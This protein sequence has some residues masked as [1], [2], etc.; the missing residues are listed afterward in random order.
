LVDRVFPE[1]SLAALRGAA[2]A[3]LAASWADPEH[4]PPLASAPGTVPAGGAGTGWVGRLVG[5][6]RRL[7]SAS[8]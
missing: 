3:A 6:V 5:V 7:F 4:A 8:S 2:A 1:E